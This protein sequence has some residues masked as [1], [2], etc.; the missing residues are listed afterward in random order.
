MIATRNNVSGEFYLHGE[1]GA[2][3]MRKQLSLARV[4]PAAIRGIEVS[5]IM[6]VPKIRELID[7]PPPASL[8]S[9]TD[10][11]GIMLG[12]D[13]LDFDMRFCPPRCA[14]QTQIRSRLSRTKLILPPTRVNSYRS[15]RMESTQ[16]VR[17][18]RPLCT[19]AASRRSERLK[20]KFVLTRQFRPPS[21]EIEQNRASVPVLVYSPH[22][23][24]S[25]VNIHENVF[26][27]KPG[28]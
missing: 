19:N 13:K 28:A 9:V 14:S 4:A 22:S 16:T 26:S 5:I 3:A 24:A 11:V 1:P 18:V 23:P 17:W 7:A 20:L 12:F 21:L 25:Q 8:G 6:E 27:I 2:S 15:C 10:F